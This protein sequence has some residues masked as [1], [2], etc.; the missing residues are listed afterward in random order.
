MSSIVILKDGMTKEGSRNVQMG[1]DKGDR[2]EAEQEWATGVKM[3]SVDT[4]LYVCTRFARTD[5]MWDLKITDAEQD[6][7][8]MRVQCMIQEVEIF[9]VLIARDSAFDS[10]LSFQSSHYETWVFQRYNSTA[11]S[12]P[13]PRLD[14]H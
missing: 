1:V 11:L 3:T 5:W 8:R 13:S 7:D 10:R 6:L 9:R 4:I 2:Y 12:A 14:N